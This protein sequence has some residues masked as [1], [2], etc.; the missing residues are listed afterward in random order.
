MSERDKLVCFSFAEY[1]WAG[2][3]LERL[4]KINPIDI[5][6]AHYGKRIPMSQMG[7]KKGT[8]LIYPYSRFPLMYIP[9]EIDPEIDFKGYIFVESSGSG[10]SIKDSFVP[11]DDFE[12]DF[13]KSLEKHDFDKLAKMDITKEAIHEDNKHVLFRFLKDIK[14][15]EFILKNVDKENVLKYLFESSIDLDKISYLRKYYDQ[16]T[17]YDYLIQ[18]NNYGY[19]DHQY[20]RNVVNL[21][22]YY[23]IDDIKKLAH[24]DI[25]YKDPYTVTGYNLEKNQMSPEFLLSKSIKLIIWDRIYNEKSMFYMFPMEIMQM[26]IEFAKVKPFSKVMIDQISVDYDKKKYKYGFQII[27]RKFVHHY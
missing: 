17:F 1:D 24:D 22:F 2:R 21:F 9:G 18:R 15:L 11:R 4:R 10:F 27:D 23:G 12:S 26:I 16:Q 25:L 13:I 8:V 7:L 20:Y 3:I 6:K 5:Q 14:V 19:I